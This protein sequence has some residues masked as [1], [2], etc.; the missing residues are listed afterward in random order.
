[1]YRIL[2]CLEVK[3]RKEEDHKCGERCCPNCDSWYIGEHKCYMQIKEIKKP[4]EK[5]IFYDFETT[6]NAEGKH[7]IN[8]CIAQYFNGKEFTFHTLDELLPWLIFYLC[9]Y[10]T[11]C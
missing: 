3:T 9:L 7:I 5:Y 6:T 1:M 10:V 11:L 8:Y 4:S 2:R